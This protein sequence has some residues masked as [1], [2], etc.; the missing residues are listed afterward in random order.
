MAEVLAAGILFTDGTRV[1][2]GYHPSVHAWSGIGGKTEEGETPQQTAIRE[3]C[4]EVFGLKPDTELL[5]EMA[6][7]FS[8]GEPTMMGD[9]AL[10][11]SEFALLLTISDTLE[12]NGY[13]CQ[14]YPS[15][16]KTLSSLIEARNVPETA[17]V[18]ALTFILIEELEAARESMAPE[19]YKDILSK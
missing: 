1:L 6:V 8:L 14:F 2:S 16:P 9:Y 17:E 18:Q 7:I 11:R 13:T 10:F 4:E 5:R 19:F 12:K 15:F 3:C